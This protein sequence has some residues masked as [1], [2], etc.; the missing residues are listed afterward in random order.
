[1]PSPGAPPMSIT[2]GLHRAARETPELA[3]TIFADRTR[4]WAQCHDRVARLAG[5]LQ[6]LGLVDGGRVAMLAMNSDG[7]HEYLL[8]VPWAGGVVTPVNVRWSPAEIA[9]SLV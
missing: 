9:F 1:M 7:Y 2:Q 8:A 3:A 4:T 5:A 6:R